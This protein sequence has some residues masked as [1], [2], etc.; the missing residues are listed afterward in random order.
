MPLTIAGSAATV[1]ERSPPPSWRMTIEPGRTARS[2]PRTIALAVT[3]SRQSAE[4]T[5]QSTTRSPSLLAAGDGHGLPLERLGPVAA[6][7][8]V[9]AI[10]VTEPRRGGGAAPV[11]ERPA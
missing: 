3:P 11:E 2:T 7:D 4:S 6:V 8:Q 5:D 9:D 1:A 10:A